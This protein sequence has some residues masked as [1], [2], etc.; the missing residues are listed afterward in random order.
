MQL[1][2]E[3]IGDFCSRID[4]H[5]QPA[6]VDLSNVCFIQPFALV[7]LGMFLRFHN[8]K[9]FE[10]EMKP[11]EER[12]V[13]EYLATQN[14][15]ERFNFSPEVIQEESLYRFTTSTSLDDIV[16]IENRPYIGDDIALIG[17][18]IAGQQ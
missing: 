4:M 2:Y 16:D 14:F 7:Y 11:P 15:W 12:F 3:N 10:F 1:S 13:R 5:K 18:G 17:L 8:S 9:G 6:L